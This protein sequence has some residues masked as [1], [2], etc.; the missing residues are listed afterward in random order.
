M[1]LVKNKKCNLLI[2]FYR[3]RKCFVGDFKHV[4]EIDSPNSRLV[5][6]NALHA[7]VENQRKQIEFLH[8]KNAILTE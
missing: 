8:K 2:K 5:I 7:T 1:Y 3:K 4:K 6:W